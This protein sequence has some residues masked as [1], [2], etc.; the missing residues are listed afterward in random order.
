MA[1]RHSRD[2]MPLFLTSHQSRTGSQNVVRF[3]KTAMTMCNKIHFANVSGTIL[4]HHLEKCMHTN[5]QPLGGGRIRTG[6]VWGGL[7]LCYSFVRR[8]R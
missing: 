2:N 6:G 5:K 7:M 3:L 4:I 8:K 1:G